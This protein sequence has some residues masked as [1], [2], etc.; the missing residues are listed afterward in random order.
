MNRCTFYEHFK[1]KQ[2]GNPATYWFKF[3]NLNIQVALCNEHVIEKGMGM[4]A[5]SYEEAVIY[6][7]LSE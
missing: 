4:E 1:S 6:Q 3:I 2:C 7:V 5:I